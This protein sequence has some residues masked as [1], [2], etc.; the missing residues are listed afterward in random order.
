MTLNVGEAPQSQ[1]DTQ[2]GNETK[3]GGALSQNA[4]TGIERK[5]SIEGLLQTGERT[6][7]L[8]S[9]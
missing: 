3:R 1:T 6:L 4:H 2:T 7:N 5:P 9:P 8:L